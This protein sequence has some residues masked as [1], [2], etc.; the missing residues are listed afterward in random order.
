LQ[1]SELPFEGEPPGELPDSEAYPSHAT[2]MFRLAAP[3]QETLSRDSATSESL[4]HQAMARVQREVESN[5]WQA[6]WRC[7]VDQRTTE[8]VAVSLAMTPA[9]VRQ[10]RSRVLRR[11]RQAMDRLR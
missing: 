6:F 1:L 7:V 3:G 8:E 5:T 2:R 9:N 4:L 11:L 10:C